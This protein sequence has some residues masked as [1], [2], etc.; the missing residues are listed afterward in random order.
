VTLAPF[1]EKTDCVVQPLTLIGPSRIVGG[2]KLTVGVGLHHGNIT[3]RRKTGEG[4]R[5]CDEKTRTADLGGVADIIVD[6]GT[7]LFG[8]STQMH[9]T[10]WL[11]FP[12]GM[13]FPLPADIELEI[14]ARLHYLNASNKPITVA[15]AYEWYTID[16][17]SVRQRLAPF[18]WANREFSIPPRSVFTASTSCE[19]GLPMH[20]VAV[21]PHMHALGT[22]FDASYLGGARDGQRFLE[23]KGYDPDNG[24]MQRFDPPVD[25]GQGEGAS[26][27]CT[28]NNT[29]DTEI[30]HGLGKNEM[31][32][33]F[34]Y[35]YPPENSY[36]LLGNGQNCLRLT[37]FKR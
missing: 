6:G 31:C 8:S 26:F 36:T 11:T 2:G 33:L 25:L 29:Y 3:T 13:G 23:S 37:P 24:V 27:S 30:H 28:W 34:G 9:G 20:V 14:V 5:A 35:A 32:V 18:A 12:E 4:A 22:E 15:P 21:L 7:V 19:F 17:A 1:E 16:E 10:E